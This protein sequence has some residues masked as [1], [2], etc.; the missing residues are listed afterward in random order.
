MGTTLQREER[1]EKLGRELRI[2]F[3]NSNGYARGDA[4]RV[5]Y[6]AESDLHSVA[7]Q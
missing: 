5:F 1:T 3:R 7:T 4:S 6:A 2:V